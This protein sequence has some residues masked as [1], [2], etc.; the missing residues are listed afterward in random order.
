MKKRFPVISVEQMK[1][2]DQLA[3]ETGLSVLQMMEHAALQMARHLQQRFPKAEKVLIL[4]GSGH[5]GGD[6]IACA[7]FLQNWG[8]SPI[9]LLAYPETKL[10][11]AAKQHLDLLKKMNIPI[12]QSADASSATLFEEADIL[13]D[14]LLG[15]AIEGD[16][17]EPLATL[18]HQANATYKPVIAFDTPSGLDLSSGKPGNPCVKADETLTLAL[19]KTGLLEKEAAEYVGEL[20]LVDLGIPNV[21]FSKAGIE[22]EKPLFTTNSLIQLV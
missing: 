12:H 22:M 19:P 18:I 13:V 14:A 21:V 11:P 3:I 6:G 1:A 20:F 10:K 9:I 4:A 16:P 2:I 15:Y 5:N 8:Y 17:R 7:R